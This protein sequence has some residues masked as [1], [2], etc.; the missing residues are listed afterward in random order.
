[1]KILNFG[2]A[3]GLSVTAV[4]AYAT[5]QVSLTCTGT[6]EES[7]TLKVE[8]FTDE[9]S[10]V[11]LRESFQDGTQIVRV[12]NAEER[13]ARNYRISDIYEITRTIK[14]VDTGWVIEFGCGETREITCLET[15]H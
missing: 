2:L 10:V 9:Q 13:Q 7:T 11:S 12:L 15:L 3:L 4:S 8:V 1:M 14:P 6:F 5:E